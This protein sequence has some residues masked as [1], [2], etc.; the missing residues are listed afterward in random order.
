MAYADTSQRT[1]RLGTIASELSALVWIAEEKGLFRNNDV[2]VSIKTYSSGNYAVQDLLTGQLDIATCT[3]FAALGAILNDPNVRLLGSIDKA[4]DQEVISRKDSGI[5]ALTDLQSRRIGLVFG[6]NAHFHLDSLLIR[7][8]VPVKDIQL[9]NI[10]PEDQASALKDGLVDAVVA[11]QPYAHQ[12][13]MALEENAI[14]WPAQ[15]GLNYY[16]VLITTAKKLTDKKQVI[17]R[18]CSALINAETYIRGNPDDSRKMLA[19]R[20]MLSYLKVTWPNH[21]FSLQID[22]PLITNMETQFRW[23][24]QRNSLVPETPMPNLLNFINFGVLD[25]INPSRIKTVH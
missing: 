22:R 8:K 15:S 4:R 24:K 3:E 1:I 9:V 10:K 23:M 11:W 18:F 20:F 6:S 14:S 2:N 12:V 16:W 17:S 13:N 25:E 5:T 7:N 21:D 19:D